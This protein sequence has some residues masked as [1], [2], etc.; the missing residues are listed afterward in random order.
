MLSYYYNYG[1]GMLGG[2]W[3]L[4]VGVPL[5]IGLW[6]QFRVKHAFKHLLKRLQFFLMGIVLV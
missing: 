4:L 1:G 6:A 5:I 2:N 3:L